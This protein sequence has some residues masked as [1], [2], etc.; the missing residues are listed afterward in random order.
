MSDPTGSLS[1][2]DP[3]H[4]TD[5]PVTTITPGAPATAQPTSAEV[6]HTISTSNETSA[7]DQ[8]DQREAAEANRGRIHFGEQSNINIDQAHRDFDNLRRQ[9]TRDSLL[10]QEQEQHGADDAAE[11]GEAESGGYDLLEQFKS[12][13]QRQEEAGISTA[14]SGV[15]WRNL[16]VYGDDVSHSEIGFFLTPFINLLNFK[17]HLKHLFTRSSDSYRHILHNLTGYVG[18]GE[19]LLILGRPGSGC[20]TLLRVLANETRTY[21]RITGD[22]RFSGIPAKEFAKHYRGEVQYNQEDDAHHPTL[23][24]KQTLTFAAKCKVPGKRLQASKKTYVETIVDNLQTMYGLTAAAG[25]LVGNAFIRG[26]SG[27]ERKR[28]SIAE[29][30]ATRSSIDIWDGSTRGLDAASALDYVKSLRIVCDIMGKA[31]IASIYQASEDIYRQFDRVLV[32][33]KGRCFYHGPISEAVPYFYALGYS[34]PPRETTPDFLTSLSDPHS[35]HVRPGYEDRAPKTPEEFEARWLAS[36]ACS[37]IQSKM[38]LYEQQGN[39]EQAG[40]NFR[41]AVH[42]SKQKHASKKSP[43]TVSFYQQF[44]ACF[45]REYQLLLGNPTAN[46]FRISFNVIMGFVVGSCFY[47]LQ[48][49][50]GGAFARGGVLFFALLFN[51]FS[52]NAELN[53]SMYGRPVLYKHKNF[54]IHHPSAMFL[55]KSIMDVPIFA[56][57]II[58]FSVILYFL[59]GLRPDAGAFFVFLAFILMATITNAAFFRLIAY[60]SPNIDLAHTIS[61]VSLIS[62]IL[63]TGY[64]IPYS[65]MRG[66][67][68]WIYWINPLAYALGGLMMNEFYGLT[69]HCGGSTLVPSGAPQYSNLANQVCTIKG[70]TPGSPTVSGN[71]YLQATINLPTSRRGV[72]FVALFAFACLYWFCC[73]L[74][75][76]YLE[77]G[78]GGYTVNK[79]KRAAL[80]EREAEEKAEAEKAAAIIAN[81]NAT[82]DA[83]STAVGDAAPFLWKNINYTV[84]VKSEPSGKRQLL[85]NVSG[86][87]R[88]GNLT[89]LMGSSGAGKT[90]LMDVLVRRKTTG[91]IEGESLLCGREPGI[92]FK[93]LTGYCEQMDVHNEFAT[94]R[95]TLRFSAEMRQP[96]TVPLTEKYEYVDKIITLLEM[97]N[98]ADALIG[99]VEHGVGISVEERK[100]LTIAIELVAKPRVLFLD[101]PTSGLDS[102]S[103]LNIVR[104]LRMLADQGQSIL[105]TI[106]QPSSLL[107]DSFDSLLL[108]A[109]GGHTVYFGDLGEDSRTLIDYFESN[110]ADRCP[111]DYNPAEYILDVVG[112]GTAAKKTLDWVQIWQDSRQRQE[113]DAE[114]ERLWAQDIAEA[115]AQR[116][117]TTLYAQTF[118]AQMRKVTGRALFDQWRNVHYN[119]ARI[120]LQVFI[121][122]FLGLSFIQLGDGTVALQNRIFALFQTAVLGITLINTVQPLFFEERNLFIREQ[123]QGFYSW[124]PWTFSVIVAELPYAILSSTLFFVI[125]Y[126][127]VGF[128]SSSDRVGY[129]YITYIVFIFFALSLGQMIASWMPN[130][131]AASMVNPFLGSMLALFCGVTIP[132][133]TMPA[134]WSRWMYWISTYH[135]SVESFVVNDLHGKAVICKSEE[136]FEIIPPANQTCGS[137]MSDFFGAGAPGYINNPED[138]TSCQY[139]PFKVGDEFYAPYKWSFDHRWRNFGILIGFC[140]FN[141]IVTILGSRRFRTRK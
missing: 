137:Y 75:I 7:A 79:F 10:S 3:I 118:W 11:K 129:F 68:I 28:L 77:Y 63:Y 31:T 123:A 140:V 52:A 41:E 4:H 73:A 76:E 15:T 136:F 97:D 42:Q 23:T 133:D 56:V 100:R 139:C 9:L 65:A 109:R 13:R 141:W 120:V 27:G 35:R 84:P 93:R 122:L 74:A 33:D 83:S 61:A 37:T 106:H 1:Q 131:F 2:G 48:P 78:K 94:V 113:M 82:A 117:Y 45:V 24:V 58:I 112:A 138:S 108:L 92:D 64:L 62:M 32:I 30:F 46:V 121:A 53:A 29:Q 128:D 20:S 104:F 81:A 119:F 39:S 19:M 34:K 54:A 57:N 87:S 103:A 95:E 12:V 26:I 85:R 125:F 111:A 135:Y 6:P 59:A 127:A 21:K 38:D 16:N 132:P 43:Y 5:D 88:P 69:L 36:K 130:L 55:A 126:F 114:L 50:S 101:E 91:V 86:W 17:A 67:F 72:W 124:F 134:F 44:K 90:T 99:N 22:V 47:N 71:D 98:I 115:P 60:I 51:A 96:T 89:A 14:K 49:D 116:P 66:W 70:A 107:F 105:C 8:Q 40:P 80:K 102:Q 18:E 25:T 110:G